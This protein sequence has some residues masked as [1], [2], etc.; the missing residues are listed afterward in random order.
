MM[1][2]HNDSLFRR[3]MLASQNDALFR[4]TMMASH[5]DA[6]FHRTMMASHTLPTANESM[7]DNVLTLIGIL[8]LVRYPG[9]EHKC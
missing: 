8:T 3:S 9:S 6:F 5:N 4:R 2:S 1:A 7:K